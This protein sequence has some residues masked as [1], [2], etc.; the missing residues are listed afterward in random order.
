VC[1][2]VSYLSGARDMRATHPA[3]GKP[4]GPAWVCPKVLIR[5]SPVSPMLLAWHWLSRAWSAAAVESF[6]QHCPRIDRMG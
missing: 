2:S 1:R 4:R 6:H 3:T 5:T